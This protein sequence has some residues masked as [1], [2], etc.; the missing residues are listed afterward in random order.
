M[1][2]EVRGPTAVWVNV[3]QEELCTR[4]TEVRFIS[5]GQVTHPQSE[6]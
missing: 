1:E 6:R 3:S 4:N 2:W 5:T